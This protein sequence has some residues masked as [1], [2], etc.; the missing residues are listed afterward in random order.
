MEARR[1]RSEEINLIMGALAKAQGSYKPLIANEDFA[2]RKYSNLQAIREATRDS[3]SANALAFYQYIE[4]LDEGSGAAL[5]H[6]ILGHESGQWISSCARVIKCKNQRD[7]SN[8]YEIEKR[9][10]ALMVLGIAPSEND[11]ICFDDNG[12]ALAEQ[13]L[14]ETFRK[15]MDSKKEELNR[16]NVI[17]KT[18]YNELMIELDGYPDIAKDIMQVYEIQTIADLP[19]EEYHKVRAKILKIK[20]NIEEF[21]RKRAR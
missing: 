21:E 5:L 10:H 9:V 4:L 13:A 18:E 1:Y 6:T 11:P 2:G 20:R 14:V 3:L 7:T 17:N 16:D 12:E 15:P 8:S 19:R